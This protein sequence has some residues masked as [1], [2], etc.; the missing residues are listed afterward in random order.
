MAAGMSG[1]I[2]DVEGITFAMEERGPS[3][4]PRLPNRPFRTFD[5]TCNNLQNHGAAELPLSRLVQP[6]NYQDGLGEPRTTGAS[7]RLL[8]SPRSVSDFVH[9]DELRARESTILLMQWGQFLDHDIALSPI[10]TEGGV[11]IRCCRRGN[12][13]ARPVDRRPEPCFPILFPEPDPDFRGSCMEFV[14]SDPAE[15]N[16]GAVEKGVREQ[17]NAVTAFI[18]GSMVYGS[19]EEEARELRAE[20]GRGF[21]MEVTRSPQGDL[22][23]QR[24]INNCIRRPNTTDFCFQAGDARVNEQP[25][26]I[27]IHTIFVNLHNK[28]ADALK[29]ANPRRSNEAVFQVTRKIVGGVIQNIMYG[30]WLPIILGR[31]TMDRL[32]LT[33]G[34]RSQYNPAIDPTVLTE[35]STAAYRMGHSLVPNALP[36]GFTR[37]RLRDH[38][39]RPQVVVRSFQDI[40]RGLINGTDSTIVDRE[41]LA[42]NV[43]RF[44]AMELTEH[45]FEPAGR[46]RQG[47]DLV[48]FNIQR[49]RDHGLPS[50]NDVRRQ[51]GFNPIGSFN[52][53]DLGFDGT[54]LARVYE[55]PDDIELFP[56]GLSERPFNGGL[57]GATFNCIIGTQMQL[58]KFGDRYFFEHSQRPEG[59]TNAQLAV[60]R[61]FS[62]STVL[63]LTINIEEIQE[64]AFQIATGRNRIVPCSTLLARIGDLGTMG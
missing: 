29:Q 21:R 54:R 24:Q 26:L 18:D 46:P 55:S 8:P 31:A 5:G 51:C 9:T 6:A 33:V 22:L 35:F 50:F 59:F 53:T 57:V 30:E 12:D 56:G 7:G 11:V 20:D 13:G 10:P 60:I 61:R 40:A 17:L 14:R 45:L 19:S 49:G 23:P 62:M 47:F 58:L 27:T 64:N 38:F 39:L 28:I 15:E 36:A 48:A 44:V 2:Q 3:I 16:Y 34:R 1:L 41:A 63:C 42:R 37:L 43:D 32:G 25:G 4:C 52:D